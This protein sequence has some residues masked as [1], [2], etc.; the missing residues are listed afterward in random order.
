MSCR[1]GT[2]FFPIKTVVV[3]EEETG[4]SWGKKQQIVLV[5]PSGQT[6]LWNPSPSLELEAH[7]LILIT[8]SLCATLMIIDSCLSLWLISDTFLEPFL[9]DGD[10]MLVVNKTEL[11]SFVLSTPL[12]KRFFFLSVAALN[13]P[14]WYS[15]TGKTGSARNW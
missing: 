9:P 15:C 2:S 4:S 8:R 13:A 3:L 6:Q 14:L 12:V 1:S 5:F 11:F 10:N 7:L